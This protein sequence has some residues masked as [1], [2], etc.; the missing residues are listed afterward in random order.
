MIR[1]IP[2]LSAD[3]PLLG[4]LRQQCWAATYRGIYPDD[5]IDKFDYAWHTAR[6]LTRITSSDFDVCIIQDNDTP[7]GYM[8]IRH[9]EPP[10]LYSLYLLPAHQHR[11]IGRMAFIR[12]TEY[13]RRQDKAYFLCHCQPE[14]NNAIAFYQ[15]MGGIIISRDENNE[16]TFMNSVT[17]RFDV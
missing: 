7:V 9:S 11:G 12:M 16:E 2:A 15:R 14:N 5:M 8:V 10:L 3:A 1:F 6:D 4:Q 17:F 13:C